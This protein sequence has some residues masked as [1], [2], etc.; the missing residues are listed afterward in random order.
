MNSNSKQYLFASIGVVIGNYDN[1]SNKTTQ[2]YVERPTLIEVDSDSKLISS[3]TSFEKNFDQNK[4]P[5]N[6][7]KFEILL[8]GKFICCSRC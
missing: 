4:L 8:P 5:L 7:K 1:E 3:I 6:T 2:Q